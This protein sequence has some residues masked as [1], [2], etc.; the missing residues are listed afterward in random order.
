MSIYKCTSCKKLFQRKANLDYHI[1][2]NVCNGYNQYNIY[3]EPYKCRFCDKSFTTPQSLSRH[4]NHT[5]KIKKQNDDEKEAILN[6]LMILEE[7]SKKEITHLKEENEKLKREVEKISN[8][9]NNTKLINNINNGTIV[10]G[11]LNNIILVGYGKE[12]M[13]KLSKQELFKVLRTGFN[14]ALNLTEAVHFNPRFP[15]YHNIYISNMKDKYAMMFDGNDWML[16]TKDVL[17]NQIYEDKKNYIEENIDEFLDS[18][19]VSRKNSLER[20]LETDE[21][22]E[23]IKNI[24]EHIKLLLYNKKKMVENN[25]GIT[26]NRINKLPN[27]VPKTLKAETA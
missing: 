18:L 10:N 1:E 4:I 21:N 19:T 9:T 27:K 6:R 2:K 16:T 11:T 26:D 5:C 20:W 17:I 22:D 25:I 3:D 15:E 12:D 8:N 23:K 14:S 7:T 24:K 13:S